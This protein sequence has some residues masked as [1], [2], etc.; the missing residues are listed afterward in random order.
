MFESILTATETS[1][2]AGPAILIMIEA[3][4]LGL[5]IAA[6]Y[7]FTQKNLFYSKEYVITVS[8]LPAIVA[9]II[10]LV[11]SSVARALSLAGAFALVRFRSAQGTAKEIVFL[12]FA[13]GI[14]LAQGLGFVIFAPVATLIICLCMVLVCM[15]PFGERVCQEKLLKVTVPQELD[16]NNEFSDLFKEYT[17]EYTLKQVKT[18]DK[19]NAYELSYY[20]IMKIG[21]DEKLFIESIRKRNSG[22]NISLGM[23]PDKNDI[24]L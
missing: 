12:F 17:K 21:I 7:M 3:F 4:V 15:T 22:L 16:Y 18:T 13:M 6:C 8:I 23:M 2:S 19:G 10:M 24:V 11:G 5:L 1:I 20:V 14:G 9:L